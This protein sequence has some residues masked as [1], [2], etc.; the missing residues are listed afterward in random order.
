VH[1]FGSRTVVRVI[2]GVL[3]ICGFAGFGAVEYT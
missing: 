2:V 3:W 1:R